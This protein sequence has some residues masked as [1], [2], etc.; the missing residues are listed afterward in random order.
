MSKFD[1]SISEKVIA[2]S[3][4]LLNLLGRKIAPLLAW[5]LLFSLACL[6]L[7][8][9]KNDFGRNPNSENRRRRRRS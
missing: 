5:G 3:F 6:A 7:L 4:K 2:I 1:V 8:K 9:L